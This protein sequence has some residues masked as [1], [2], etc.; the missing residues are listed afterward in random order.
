MAGRPLSAV[1]NI[2]ASE[3]TGTLN[4]ISLLDADF[5]ALC[6]F[7][8][9]SAI[10]YVNYG[11]DTGAANAYVVTLAEPPS[12]YIAG[13]M[14]VMTPAN[15]N[16][17]ASN[18]N[19]NAIGAVPI[20]NRANIALRGGEIAANKSVLLVFDGTSFR[21]ISWCSGT[22]T[23]SASTGNQ[24]FNCAGY[25][26]V[27]IRQIQTSGTSAMVLNNLG[28][29][30][31][32][33]ITI[34]NNTGVPQLFSINPSDPAGNAGIALAV[35]PGGVGTQINLSSPNTFTVGNALSRFFTSAG[36]ASPGGPVL[37]FT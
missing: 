34:L 21:I 10:G 17:G 24:T 29:G 6:S 35:L 7:F 14:L 1:P 5:A 3:G 30:V 18:I 36:M 4:N 13:M 31:P 23:L 28:Y 19:V 8:S 11:V 25:D 26:S 9:D 12:A 15:S 2:F 32:V 27:S 37:S 16:T 22:F 20:V 33:T